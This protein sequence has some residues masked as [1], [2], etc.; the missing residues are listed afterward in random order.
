MMA[1]KGSETGVVPGGRA[2]ARALDVLQAFSL[3]RPE[4]AVKE[5]ADAVDLPRP[6]VYRIVAV[7]ASRGF[8]RMNRETGVCRPGPALADIAAIYYSQLDIRKIA[9]DHMDAL[10]RQF[11]QTV[12]L[13]VRDDDRM[14]YVD[15]RESS[16]S[17]RV[18]SQVL[19]SRAL[20]YGGLGRIV[21]PSRI[22]RGCAA[23]WNPRGSSLSPRHRLLIP[24]RSWSPWSAPVQ[25][26]STLK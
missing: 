24:P 26:V 22:R 3:E 15:K 6:T 7:L 2:V 25:T 19:H 1:M 10:H 20:T 21:S 16:R 11:R 13:A 14:I 12:L 4:L 23:S 8:L 17:L 18:T 5:I 9:S